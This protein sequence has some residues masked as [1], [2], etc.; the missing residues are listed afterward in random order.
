MLDALREELRKSDYLPVMFD[1]E[2]PNT[3]DLTE[4][5]ST[6]AHMAKFVIADLTDAKRLPQE[7]SSIVPSLRSVPLRPILLASEREWA[8]YEHFPRC[9]WV[10]P[11]VLYE[12][13]A[14]VIETLRERVIK[15]AERKR[16]RRIQR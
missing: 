8:M 15:P 16:R 1:F 9:P 13:A 4:T 5:V 6:L 11:T 10:L 12:T 3:R 2:R 7:F 14:E